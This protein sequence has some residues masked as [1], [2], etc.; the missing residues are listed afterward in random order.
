[1]TARTRI[2]LNVFPDDE[3]E[4]F[5]SDEAS[6]A[7]ALVLKAPR[8]PK[9][10]DIL[11]LGKEHPKAAPDSRAK[12]IHGTDT[13]NLR[14][15]DDSASDLFFTLVRGH[16]HS[17]CGIATLVSFAATAAKVRLW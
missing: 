3:F 2:W 8:T 16:R 11:C 12:L 5:V 9:M 1:M 6:S 4:E 14:L 17:G 7:L 13:S 10:F 15:L